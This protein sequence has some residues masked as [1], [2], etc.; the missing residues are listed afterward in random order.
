MAADPVPGDRLPGRPRLWARTPPAI[1]PPLLGLFGLGLAWRAG[2]GVFGV[3]AAVG[4]L[5]L[6]AATALWLLGL[7]AWC[8][9]P[10]RRPGVIF[11]E[12]R[13]LPGRAGLAAM[14]LSGLL[15][16]AALV[17][18]AP[19]LAMALT[20]LALAAHAALAGLVIR[21]I[22][23][24][25]EEGRVLTPVWHLLF[26]GF[27]MAPLSLVPLGHVGAATAILG[28]TVPVALAIWA[29]SLAQL[30]RRFPP[31]PLRPLLAIHLAPAS[32]FAGV[33]ALL[34]MPA[35]ASG[36]AALA[37]AILLALLLAGRWIAAAG[38]SPLWGAFTFPLAA[39]AGALLALAP[40]SAAPE[41]LRLAGGL[42][43]VAATLA[44]PPILV[45]IWQGWA[46]G[47][48]AG[49]TNAASV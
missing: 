31:A 34:Q 39:F 47:D 7:V 26:V 42:V 48:L 28:L 3:P 8:A 19:R 23:T 20:L 14:T 36:F 49:R 17:P 32:L 22:L 27:I 2:A 38:F 43:L 24:G 41:A 10:L 45:K 40:I 16:A 12:L 30:L 6:G 5:L 18:H 21:L 29:A 46:R 4:D 1:F 25:P 44:I 9:K 33:A 35:L 37:G 15:L 13:V 11:E